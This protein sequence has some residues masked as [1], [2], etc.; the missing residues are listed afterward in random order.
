MKD[1]RQNQRI[2]GSEVSAA[3]VAYHRRQAAALEAML[4]MSE[5]GARIL[6]D[7][8]PPAA[9]ADEGKA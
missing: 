4:L 5:C 2:I 8:L 1:R 3:A 6:H 7:A 9:P